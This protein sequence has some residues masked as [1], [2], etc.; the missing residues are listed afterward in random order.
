MKIHIFNVF[1]M[2]TKYR[3][4]SNPIFFKTIFFSFQNYHK[5]MKQQ[6]ENAI[7]FVEN[8]MRPLLGAR[9]VNPGVRGQQGVNKGSCR[10]RQQ[11]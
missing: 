7:C 2:S 11:N 3:I 8:V 5:K 6:L 10:Y 9:L 1:D 4:H